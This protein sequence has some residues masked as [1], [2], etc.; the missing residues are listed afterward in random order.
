LE[1]E[2]MK[3]IWFR[4]TIGQRVVVTMIALQRT[5]FD[6]TVDKIYPIMD[7]EANEKTHKDTTTC[8]GEGIKQ[9]TT[10]I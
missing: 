6:A 2:V 4:V 9:K 10:Q 1:L 3:M 7:E 8:H 5:N